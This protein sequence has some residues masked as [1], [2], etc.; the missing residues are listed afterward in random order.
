MELLIKKR[1]TVFYM[2][3]ANIIVTYYQKKGRLGFTRLS[4][5]YQ[6]IIQGTKI[7]SSR[8]PTQNSLTSSVALHFIVWNKNDFHERPPWIH[9]N[10][11]KSIRRWLWQAESNV[12]YE[13]W[14]YFFTPKVPLWVLFCEKKN[15]CHTRCPSWISSNHGIIIRDWF[16]LLKT[17]GIHVSHIVL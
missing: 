15:C 2:Y 5:K 13:P 10:C 17:H 3:L 8:S 1:F 4:K 9:P 12:I 11:V 16:G 14:I 6:R 7:I